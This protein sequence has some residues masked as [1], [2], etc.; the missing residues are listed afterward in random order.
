MKSLFIISLIICFFE[1]N[2]VRNECHEYKP[3]QDIKE[4]IGKETGIPHLG[5]CGLNTILP[6][7][8][9][10]ACAPFGNTKASKE[11]LKEMSDVVKEKAGFTLD[12]QCSSQN[13]EIKGTCDEFYGIAVSDPSDCL[14]LTTPVEK[15]TTCCGLKGKTVYNQYGVNIELASSACLPLPK[16]E[17]ERDEYIKNFFNQSEWKMILEY[18]TCGNENH[19]NKLVLIASVYLMLLLL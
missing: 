1:I 8:Q 18:Y 15:N 13:D 9:T 10:K 19:F 12:F 14:K 6:T 16:D 4:C 17:N 11:L 2:A 7:G 5:C 3:S